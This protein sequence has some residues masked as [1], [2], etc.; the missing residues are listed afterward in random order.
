[1]EFASFTSPD[2]VHAV[3]GGATQPAWQG[4]PLKISGA[5]VCIQAPGLGHHAMGTVHV[6]Y[7][8][9]GFSTRSSRSGRL[10]GADD[11]AFKE[12]EIVQV[13]ANAQP[14]PLVSKDW[15]R[16]TAN[17]TMLFGPPRRIAC[18]GCYL[19]LLS[20]QPTLG[21]GGFHH[22]KVCVSSVVRRWR[23]LACFQ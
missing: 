21:I 14:P 5:N 16:F 1:M 23:I 20:T 3:S 6:I 9:K 22:F 4:P 15:H 8:V 10:A 18:L 19:L 2:R 17:M 11:G 7:L 13:F 12:H